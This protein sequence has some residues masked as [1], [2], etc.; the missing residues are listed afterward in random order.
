MQESQRAYLPAAGKD[1]ALPF[2][3]PMVKLLG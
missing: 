2:Y 1:W 3:D